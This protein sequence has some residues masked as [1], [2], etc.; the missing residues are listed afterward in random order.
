M[1]PEKSNIGRRDFLQMT[2]AGIVAAGA[3]SAAAQDLGVEPVGGT[4]SLQAGIV[5]SPRHNS[6]RI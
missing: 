2:G 6:P 1:V 3:G 5:P 4:R